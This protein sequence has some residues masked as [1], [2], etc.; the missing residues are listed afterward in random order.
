MIRG[1]DN[2]PFRRR[3][4]CQASDAA[5]LH[6]TELSAA[7]GSPF[8]PFTG[9][10]PPTEPRPSKRTVSSVEV[11]DAYPPMMPMPPMP[12]PHFPFMGP[13]TA[14]LVGVNDGRSMPAMPVPT[15]V[16]VVV[17]DADPIAGPGETS[18]I[19]PMVG[20]GVGGESRYQTE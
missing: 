17:E 5:T 6:A 19:S 14:I 4:M 2:N 20:Y 13:K 7:P 16:V 11:P 3:G 8:L 9:T 1:A 12:M 15:P 18:L 10:L